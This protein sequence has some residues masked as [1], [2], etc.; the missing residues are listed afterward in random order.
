M[1]S[2][3]IV[4]ARAA[5]LVGVVALS[6]ACAKHDATSPLLDVS[7]SI[8]AGGQSAV[9][10]HQALQ[11]TPVVRDSNGAALTG[12]SVS[13]SSSDT[14]IASVSAS[15]VVTGRGLGAVI[16][17]ATCDAAQSAI[18]LTVVL[19]VADVTV[20][21]ESIGSSLAVGGSTQ[22]GVGVSD[23]NGNSIFGLPVV[24]SSSN[25]SLAT[26]TAASADGRVGALS[27]AASPGTV[28]I[29][30]TVGGVTGSTLVTI[31]QLSAVAS[32][33]V[34]PKTVTFVANSL[35]F[36][37]GTQLSVIA[38]DATGRSV[39]GIPVTWSISNPG[40]AGISSSGLLTPNTAVL[41]GS[42]A[43]ATVIGMVGTASDSVS[44]VVCPEITS[45]TASTT[46]IALQVGQSVTVAA[47]ALDA[48]GNLDLAPLNVQLVSPGGPVVSLQRVGVDSVLLTGT[49]AGTS[50]LD[51]FDPV[52]G[53]KSQTISISVTA[54]ESE[55]SA[56]S[57]VGQPTYH[58]SPGEPRLGST[59]L[60]DNSVVIG[61]YMR[62][63]C[64]IAGRT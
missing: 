13:W 18:Q 62:S 46:S 4:D 44:V 31:V 49:A 22:M 3:K 30:A 27:A 23:S 47:T 15:G 58:V 34:K 7:L 35:G 54:P 41:A 19:P 24:W 50:A 11:L 25:T 52:S 48:R 53:T 28:T 45:I 39:L 16:V 26:I 43:T 38:L 10:V 37:A 8:S 21:F 64:A 1:D 60:R 51:F 33:S 17:T 20:D 32:I 63:L 59:H 61:A 6:A 42:M 40:A 36:S 55:A 14:T 12:Q 29:S 5:I 9:V 2:I 56:D 57:D